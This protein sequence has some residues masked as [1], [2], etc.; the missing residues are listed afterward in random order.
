MPYLQHV[1]RKLILFTASFDAIEDLD[2]I[3]FIITFVCPCILPQPIFWS[4]TGLN[5]DPDMWCTSFLS[6]EF[7]AGQSKRNPFQDSVSDDASTLVCLTPTAWQHWVI[8]QSSIMLKSFPAVLLPRQTC[9][10]CPSEVC[11]HLKLVVRWFLKSP[12]NRSCLPMRLQPF[13]LISSAELKHY[14]FIQITDE[15]TE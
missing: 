9:P 12:R 3:F 8:L 15:N 2:L 5:M 10:S 14:S 4:V 7:S 6:A 13:E 1:E 11:I